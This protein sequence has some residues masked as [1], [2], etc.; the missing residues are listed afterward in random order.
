[1]EKTTVDLSL[2]KTTV[3]FSL[4]VNRFFYNERYRD[5]ARYFY[6]YFDRKYN[7]ERYRTFNAHGKMIVYFFNHSFDLGYRQFKWPR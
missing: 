7:R 2:L 3:D 5:V 1:L 6:C 4:F